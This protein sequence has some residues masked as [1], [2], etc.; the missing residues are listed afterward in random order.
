MDATRVELSSWQDAV[1]GFVGWFL[2]AHFLFGAMMYASPSL[3]PWLEN[4][5]SALLLAAIWLPAL[6]V[7]MTLFRRNRLGLGIGIVSA[8]LFSLAGTA[9]IA[10]ITGIPLHWTSLLFPLPYSWLVALVD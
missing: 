6:I 7:P 8:A 3:P 10:P 5:L 2:Y 9:L 1:L 4:L